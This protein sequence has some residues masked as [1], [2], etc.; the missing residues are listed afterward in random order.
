MRRSLSLL[1]ALTLAGCTQPGKTTVKPHTTPAAADVVTGAAGIISEHGGSIIANNGGALTGKV[2][3]PSGIIANNA[4]SLISNNGGG[5]IANN[6]GNLISDHGVGYVLQALDEKPAS[7]FAVSI[8]DAAGKPVLDDAGKP[9]T[10]TTDAQ[11][12]YRFEKTPAGANLV[13]RVELP[14]AVGPMLAYLPDAKAGSARAAD[15]NGPSTLVMGYILAKYVKGDAKVLAKLPATVEADTRAKAAAAIGDA[16]DLKGFKPDALVPAVDGLRAKD[17]TFDQQ[18]KAVEK[19]LVAGLS[20]LGDG[21]LATAVGLSNPK[22]FARLADGSLLIAERNGHRVRKLD[23][24]TGRIGSFAGKDGSTTA[25]DGGPAA[26]AFIDRPVALAVDSQQNVYIADF[27]HGTVRRVDAKTHLITAVAGNGTDPRD[28]EGLP[29]YDGAVATSVGFHNAVFI[30][31]DE[32][33]RLVFRTG[34]GTFRLQADGKLKLLTAFDG[35]LPDSLTKGPDGKVYAFVN[36]PGQILVLEGDAFKVAGYPTLPT[37]QTTHLEFGP[38]GTAYAAVDDQLWALP[39]KS[40]TW[41]QIPITTPH[42]ELTDT[43]VADGSLIVGDTGS[44]R[45]W[46]LPLAGGEGTR[47]AG[48]DTVHG[49][50]L[51]A[52]KL[53]LN[54]PT[55]LALDPAGNL[56][57]ADGLNSVIWQRRPDG[58]FYRF[59]GGVSA[60]IAD[61]EIGDGGAA[62]DAKMLK[63]VGMTLLKD[64]SLL[65][66]E[67]DPPVVRVRE[68]LSDGT[69]ETRPMPEGLVAPALMAE[70]ADGALLVSDIL[71]KKFFRWRGKSLTEVVLDVKLSQ[72]GQPIGRPD[73][74][75]YITDVKG[76][77]IYRVK[78]GHATVVAGGN[79][80]GFGGD[81][82]DPTKAQLNNPVAI[83]LAANGDLYIAD[84]RNDRVRRVHNGK[85]ETVAG[86][87]GLVLGGATPDDSLKEPL[88]LVFDRDGNLFISDS[89]HNQI[90]KVEAAKLL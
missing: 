48:Q 9:Y 42:G 30:A 52:D 31:V 50:A 84:T 43:L 33:D 79:G 39:G 29:N 51:E 67:A 72:P 81:G 28:Q 85:L 88:G 14:P 46:K 25:G 27:G 35:T 17:P 44:N 75:Y 86:K 54:R 8:V 10:A 3:I 1:L 6:A 13:V 56:L 71:L 23:L 63:V 83:A 78:D 36:G 55:S 37:V 22:S 19:L 20:D 66:T 87:D 40:G 53:S 4:G 41:A 65:L 68:I 89:G 61:T 76:C 70:E 80:E 15:V 16:L 74:S 24:A 64:G 11:G 18:V 59:A 73:G 38:D 57:V 60:A 26:D 77:V 32:T 69:I 49:D 2:K 47:I 7:G 34:E 21:E 12:G 82:G 45:V 62:R 5:I 58:K 90:K